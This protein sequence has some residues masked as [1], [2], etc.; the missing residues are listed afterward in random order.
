VSHPAPSGDLSFERGAFLAQDKLL[1]SE[2][3]FDCHSNLVANCCVLR[4]EIELGDRVRLG[5]NLRLCG[6]GL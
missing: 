1:R 4:G 6:H 3:S 5:E 2:D